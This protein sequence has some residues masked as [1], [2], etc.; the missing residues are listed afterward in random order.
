MKILRPKSKKTA[1]IFD[2]EIELRDSVKGLLDQNVDGISIVE[3]SNYNECLLKLQKQ[4]FSLL[5]MNS[6]SINE[7]NDRF[8]DIVFRDGETCPGS[9]IILGEE[10]DVGEVS[11]VNLKNIDLPLEENECKSIIKEIFFPDKDKSRL[12]EQIVKKVSAKLLTELAISTDK[13]VESLSG[14][15]LSKDEIYKRVEGQISGDVSAVIMLHSKIFK[16]SVA[17]SFSMELFLEILGRA[18]GGL[19]GEPTKDE[20]DF[21]GEICNQVCGLLIERLVDFPTD[22]NID[23]PRVVVNTDHIVDHPFDVPIIAIRYT[24]MLGDVVMEAAI[25]G[26][27]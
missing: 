8:N 23:L 11:S 22:I 13:T 3:A 21:V 14:L 5:V 12:E 19:I 6:S 26:Q 16:A 15:K 20:L 24:T 2:E 10:K 27:I 17:L 7:D 25:E 18:Q 1:L 4:K 9:V